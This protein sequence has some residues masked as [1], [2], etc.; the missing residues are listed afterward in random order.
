MVHLL[1]DP[2]IAPLLPAQLTAPAMTGDPAGTIDA[3]TEGVPV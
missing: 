3:K 1:I 2:S